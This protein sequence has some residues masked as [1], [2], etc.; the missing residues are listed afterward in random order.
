MHFLKPPYVV[1]PFNVATALVLVTVTLF[2][3]LVVGS[4]FA[5]LWNWMHKR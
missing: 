1:Q 3:G 4:I 2:L 5:L